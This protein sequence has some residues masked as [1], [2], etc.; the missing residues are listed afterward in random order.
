MGIPTMPTFIARALPTTRA[1]RRA[2]GDVGRVVDAEV[3]PRGRAPSRAA[4]HGVGADGTPG[5]TIALP[6]SQT[7]SQIAIG[8]A[9]AQLSRA[10]SGSIGCVAVR[11]WT[12]V[13][14]S[15]AAPIAIGATSNFTRRS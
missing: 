9:D 6:P 4:D 3:D 8:V 14:T 2:G 10:G 12:R 11:S 7:L 15:H 1:E 5:Q 13:A